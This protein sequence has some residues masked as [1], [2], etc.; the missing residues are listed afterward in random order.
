MNT[1]ITRSVATM[2]WIDPRT[3]LREVDTRGDPGKQVAHDMILGRLAYRFA[4]FLEAFLRVDKDGKVLEYGFTEAS[5]MY[6]NLSYLKIPSE[7]FHIIRNK[8]ISA[9]SSVY[10]SQLVGCRTQSP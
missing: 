5:G 8:P 2:S 3:G 4:N 10:F 6:R 9:G 1:L 7:P